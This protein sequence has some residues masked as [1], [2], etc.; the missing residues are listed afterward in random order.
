MLEIPLDFVQAC[1][2][3][4]LLRLSNMAMKKVPTSVRSCSSLQRLDLSCNRIVDL[5]DAGL[6]SIPELR[7]LKIQNN[8]LEK[9]PWYFPRLRALTELNIS[10]N[11]FR[12][13]PDVIC[14]TT[15]LVDLDVSFNEIHELPDELGDLYKLETLIIVGNQVSRFPPG[16]TNLHSLKELD[17]RRNNVS[18]ISL[19][20]TLPKVKE[21]KA[22]HNSL[23]ALELSFGPSLIHLDVSHNDITQ[24]TVGH[25]Q[26]CSLKHLDIGYAKLSSIDD[27]ALSHLRSLE[28]LRVC[29][30]SIKSLPDSLGE[31][32]Q[33]RELSCSNN[34]LYALPTTIGR[35]QRLEKLEAHNNSLAELPNSL[36]ECASLRVLNVTS[37]LLGAFGPP[38]VPPLCSSSAPT[39][40]SPPTESPLTSTIRVN[41]IY[42]ERK[43]STSSN[44]SRT[45]PPLAISLEKLYL[46][47]NRLSE[48][49]LLPLRLF[50]S[51]RVLNLSFN[52]IQEIPLGLFDKMSRLEELYLSG[53]GLSALP[54]EDIHKLTSLKVLFLN[55]NKLQ[56]LPSELGKLKN[57]SFL[58]VGSN[59]LKYNIHNWE[60]DWN[61]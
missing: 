45:L 58:D 52:D 13:F 17:C 26:F 23:L 31:L 50:G 44:S 7:S 60:F 9:L 36:W 41:D 33:L 29:H 59:V 16:S 12:D 38:P 19:I 48:H 61:W 40:G 25:D 53:N 56:T 34:Q 32:R 24:L 10:N 6:D 8:R 28:M 43:V 14:K 30:N 55:G 35:L 1:T 51:L 18:D 2:T 5:D 21:I 3:L 54:T 27:S 37:N 20:C 15:N 49:V 4:R 42:A 11:K 22:N 47:E 39:T 57:L 46:G